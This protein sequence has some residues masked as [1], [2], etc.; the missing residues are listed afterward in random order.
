M[1]SLFQVGVDAAKAANRWQKQP[2]GFG[3]GGA[4]L[5]AGQ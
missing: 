3:G 1:N 5:Q 4:E 2:P